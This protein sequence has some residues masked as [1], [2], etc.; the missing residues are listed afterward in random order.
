[1]FELAKEQQD[2]LAMPDDVDEEPV[3]E[4]AST[5]RARPRQTQDSDEDD[6]D[7]DLDYTGVADIEYEEEFVSA[8]RMLMLCRL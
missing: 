8:I 1:M 3:Q 7:E 2:E 6:E 5:S 4:A